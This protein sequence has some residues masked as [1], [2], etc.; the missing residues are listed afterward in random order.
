MQK[1]FFTSDS[2]WGH[3]NI[4][5]HCNRPFS[6]LHEMNKTLV[7]NWNRTVPPDGVV[8]HLGDMF[9][10][11]MLGSLAILDRLNGKI[12]LLRGNHRQLDPKIARKRPDKIEWLGDYFELTIPDEDAARGKQLIVLFHYACLTWNKAGYSSILACGH[13]HSTLND[14]IDMHL[15]NAR[16]L[17]VGVD[18]VARYL[19]DNEALK[20]EHYRP[21]SYEELK[22]FIDLKLRSSVDHHI[23]Q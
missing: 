19:S 16:M 21:I 17:D 5:S 7:D 13:S 1:I 23:S 20:P 11:N 9:F 10:R 14:W 2:H 6:S 18:S 8:Y 22:S 15:P 3:N 4:I 12:K